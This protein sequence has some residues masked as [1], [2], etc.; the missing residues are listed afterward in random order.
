MDNTA[1]I[2]DKVVLTTE[3]LKSFRTAVHTNMAE[4]SGEGKDRSA[5]VFADRTL[6]SL[7]AILAQRSKSQVRKGAIAFVHVKV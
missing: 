2:Q 1:V 3:E 6:E 7:N 5:S 4:Y